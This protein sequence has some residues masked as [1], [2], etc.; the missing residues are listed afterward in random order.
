M[1]V[2]FGKS[3]WT[4]LCASLLLGILAEESFFRGRIGISYIVFIGSAY[5]VFFWRYRR[6]SFSHQRLGGLVLCC[7]WLL[8]ASYFLNDTLL[9]YLLNILIIPCLVIFHM[10]LVTS[11]KKL[12]WNKP[13]YIVYLL[14]KF[15]DCIKYVISIWAHIGTGVKRGVDE[16]KIVIWKKV[17]IG[18]IVSLPVLIVVLKLLMNADAH[19]D[20]LMGG[21]P[22]WFQVVD[23][24]TLIRWIVVLGFTLGFFTFLQI[25]AKKQVTYMLPNKSNPRVQLDAIIAITV[26]ILI[27]AVYV[28]FTIVQFKYFF[29]GTLQ[30]DYTFAEYARKGFFELLFVTMINL[31]IMNSILTFV[32]VS[33]NGMK[34]LT[35]IMLSV[36]ILS[37]SVM[38]CSAFLRLSMYEE[39]YGFTFI[40]VLVHSFMIFLTVIFAYTLVKIWLEKLSL[41]HFYFIASLLYYTAVS[42]IDLNR[43]VVNEN[44]HRYE[45]TGK[46]DISNFESMSSDGEIGLVELYE[47]DPHIPDLK[48]ILLE[49]KKMLHMESKVWQ[50]YNLKRAE[51]AKKILELNM[52]E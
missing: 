47:K 45:T 3:E 49:R 2:K 14:S 26:L 27:N 5:L 51:A 50:S 48:S 35:Q 33:T 43:I 31:T 12:Q 21:I 38:L 6:Y 4:F 40:R 22:D 24:E 8:T 23:A 41:F 39:A 15:L 44:I 46:V 32:H 36:L 18:I 11:P 29:G 16:G 13:L 10:V 7:I 30:K 9:F 20:R 1:E 52:K 17:G 42:V 37:S 25:L 19:F 28:L 34:R